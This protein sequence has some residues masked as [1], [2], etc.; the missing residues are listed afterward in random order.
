MSLVG[1]RPPIPREV[2]EYEDWHHLRFATL[3]GITGIWQVS[4]RAKI[5]DFNTV[6]K[7]DYEYIKNWNLLLDFYLL[8]P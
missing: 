6:V 7:M 8:M 4:G 2:I 1:P 3:P 5:K